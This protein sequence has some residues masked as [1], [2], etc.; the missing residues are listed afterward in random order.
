[1]AKMR[2]RRFLYLDGDLTDEYL[3]QAE[4]GLYE[5]E[6]QTSTGSTEKGAGLG[7]GVGPVSAKAGASS[8]HQESR[9]RKVRQTEESAFSRLA[10]L[11]N[12]ADSVQ[13]LETFDEEVWDQLDRG[14]VLEIECQLQVPKLIQFTQIG[15]DLEP[16][17]ELMGLSGEQLD[18]SALQGFAV[19][20]LIT[21]MLDGLPVFASALGAPQYSFIATLDSKHLRVPI[22]ELQGEARLYCSLERKLRDDQ[23]YSIV[24]TMPALRNLPDIE[25]AKR[26]LLENE[27]LSDS[28][29]DPPAAIVSPIAIFR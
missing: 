3:A 7:A 16:M 26:E 10:T 21:Q 24:D 1:M 4:G 18:E 19:L 9:A 22:D 12:D 2:L 29:V 25:D 23:Q 17:K 13:W 20:G 14:E 15:S 5:E 8:E 28:A 6:D 11:L 27:M